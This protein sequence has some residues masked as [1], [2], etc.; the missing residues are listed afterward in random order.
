MEGDAASVQLD[1]LLAAVLA[2]VVIVELVR[3]ALRGDFS[4]R[5]GFSPPSRAPLHLAGVHDG[6]RGDRLRGHEPSMADDS[7]SPLIQRVLS[8]A[9]IGASPGW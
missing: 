3:R 5:S 7:I 4:A 6:G 1:H 2:A 8:L 9:M